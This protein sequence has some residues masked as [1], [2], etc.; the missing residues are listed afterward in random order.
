VKGHAPCQETRKSASKQ[1][2]DQ[3]IKRRAEALARTRRWRVLRPIP[4]PSITRSSI[5]R[6]G[7]AGVSPELVS[8]STRGARGTAPAGSR[9]VV[10]PGEGEHGAAAP[11][12]QSPRDARAG[13]DEGARHRRC[14]ERL[15]A[16][17]SERGST[18]T[19]RAT[20]AMRCAARRNAIR[21]EALRLF[22]KHRILRTSIPC[23]AR[24]SSCNSGSICAPS[25]AP[26]ASARSAMRRARV[27]RRD[28]REPHPMGAP[29]GRRAVARLC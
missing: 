6:Q 16:A 23:P 21:S 17:S 3:A 18:R 4:G 8:C 14:S 1:A 9:S 27:K 20:R 10:A 11:R 5:I 13:S 15:F 29:R 25:F 19:R 2:I 12:G 28:R 22:Q 24:P 26:R 7:Q